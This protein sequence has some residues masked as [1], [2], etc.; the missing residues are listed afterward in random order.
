MA[1]SLTFTESDVQEEFFTRGW[2]DGLPVV[3]P[4]PERVDAMLAFA[5]VNAEEVVGTVPERSRD[6]TAEKA[7]INAVMAGCETQHFP[8]V[9]AALTAMCDP[10]FGC[11]T[12]VTSTGGSALCVAVSG[13]DL[14]ALGFNTTRN[15]L[16]PGYRANATVGRTM[17]LVAMN[18]LGARSDKLDGSS[19]GHPG[20]YTMLIAEEKPPEGWDPLR[21]DLGYDET[22]TTVTVLATEGPHQVSNQLNAT[23]EGVL[24]TF[25]AAMTNPATYGVGKGHQVLLVLGYEHRRILVEN[26]WTRQAIR[27][28]LAEETRV[29]PAYLEAAGIVMEHTKQNDMTPDADGKL[30]TVRSPDDI[31]LITAGSA[32]AGWSAYIPTWAPTVHSV[33]AT[34][35]VQPP[36]GGLP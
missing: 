16:G 22:D 5:G 35:K 29:T 19:I 33:A 18:V 20:K 14:E 24:A 21:V 23:P 9:L 2:T 8:V 25:V 7:A 6:I 34:K 28:H 4:T 10:A 32:G 36:S 15:A 31:F 27:E 17:R 26:G 13:P 3:P 11:H 1:E 12:A 30:A